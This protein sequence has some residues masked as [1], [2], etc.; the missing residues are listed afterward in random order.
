MMY[1]GIDIGTTNSKGILLTDEGQAVGIISISNSLSSDGCWYEQFCKIISGF[2]SQGLFKT[3]K[4]CCSIASQG[5]SFILLDKKMNPIG[6]PCLWTSNNGDSAAQNYIQTFGKSHFYNATGWEPSGWLAAFKIRNMDIATSQKVAFVPEF[7]YSRLTGELVTDIT[8]AQITG[9]ADYRKGCWDDTILSWCGLKQEQL[10][11]I[12][13]DMAVL[14]EDLY[15]DWGSIHLANGSHDQYAAMEAVGLRCDKDVMVATGTAWV[16]NTRMEKAAYDNNFTLHPGR[17]FTEKCYGNIATLGAVGNGFDALL[18]KH[19]IVYADVE[20]MAEQI[21][22]VQL[23]TQRISLEQIST[24]S[25]AHSIKRY[26]EYYAAYIKYILECA[27]EINSIE[28]LVMTGGAASSSI[29]PQIVAN[30]C[31][32]CVRAVVFNQLTAYGA[33]MFA[34]KAAASNIE[35]KL[36][37]FAKIITYYPEKNYEYENWFQLIQR[38]YIENLIERGGCNENQ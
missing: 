7:I 10:A 23:P 25:K 6:K 37:E 4:L 38:P 9:M 5:G 8:N 36:S 19:G 29:W 17:N 27:I 2:K 11:R 14:Y 26:M 12:E 16:I 21:I 34:A 32:V 24:N 31:G 1:C 33:A 30:I 13:S 3:E 20:N 22:K 28:T 18:H 15:T 35:N